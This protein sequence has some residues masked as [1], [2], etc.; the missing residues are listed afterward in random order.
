MITDEMRKMITDYALLL[1]KGGS[2]GGGTIGA[3]TGKVGLGGNSTSPAATDIDVPSGGTTTITAEKTSENTMQIFLETTGSTIQGMVIREMGFFENSGK[4]LGRV[5][6]D[7]VG[8]FN[9]SDKLQ[10]FLTVE[11]E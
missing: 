11:V 10:I 6:F 7:G 3:G 2:I 1:V 5:S 8:P 9:S 4:M